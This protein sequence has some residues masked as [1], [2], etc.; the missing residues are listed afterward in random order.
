MRHSWQISPADVRRVRDFV[1]S[2]SDRQ[3]VKKRLA[4]L[5]GPNPPLHKNRVWYGMTGCLLSTQ[6]RSGPGSATTRFLAQRPFPLA[7]PTV[8]QQRDVKAYTRKMLTAAGGIRRS[9][10]IAR[11]VAGNLAILEDRLW[12]ELMRRLDGL[13]TRAS[14]AQETATA[15]FIREHLH[16]FGPKQSRNLLQGLG[17]SR[18]E[19]PIDSRITK[20]L[21]SFG[22]PVP[23]SA[24][25]LGDPGYYAF[26]SEGIQALCSAAKVLPC[27]LDAA[28]F[29]S[30]DKDEWPENLDLW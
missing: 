12:P 8:R 29:A 4:T 18:H 6:Q 21:T 2:Q 20:W 22:F 15:D 23:L 13:Q 1:A 24:T 16:G 7:Y 14:A 9:D 26:V 10:T 30:F 27:I 28:I 19:I 5:Q 25:G 11:Q 17:L 3:F